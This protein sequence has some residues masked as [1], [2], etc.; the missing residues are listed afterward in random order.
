MTDQPTAVSFGYCRTKC[1]TALCTITGCCAVLI[2]FSLPYTSIHSYSFVAFAVNTVGGRF[3]AS[4]K[5]NSSPRTE[6]L[7]LINRSNYCSRYVS[8]GKFISSGLGNQMFYFAAALHVANLTGREV[9]LFDNHKVGTLVAVFDLNVKIL[10]D[11]CPKYGF[12]EATPS[13]DTNLEKFVL[14]KSETSNKTIVINGYFQSW[15]YLR[16]TSERVRHH[17]TFKPDTRQVATRFLQA[18]I[19]A[20]WTT[21][22]LR[23]GVHIRRGNFLEPRPMKKGY[24]VGTELYFQKAMRYFVEK[25]GRTQFIVASMDRI[26]TTKFI[27]FNDT[28][29]ANITFSFGRKAAQDMAILSMCDHVIVSTGTFGWWSGWLAGGMTIYY[30]DYPR[31]N[32]T[33]SK[34]LK[35]EDYYPTNWIPME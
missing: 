10:K 18:N 29:L 6:S 21:D 9:V 8:L 30:A 11:V 33:F 2:I 25:H 3:I 13:F 24:S 15:R 34:M 32:S 7:S 4:G 31:R 35:R 19:P 16:L 22:F 23:V 14:N 1:L 12:A 5:T 27:Y 28:A 20:G 26:W 17:F